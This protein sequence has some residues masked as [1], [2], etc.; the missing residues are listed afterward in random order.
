MGNG[1]IFAMVLTIATYD[2]IVFPPRRYHARLA[3]RCVPGTPD[4][5]IHYFLAEAD[6]VSPASIKNSNYNQ[7]TRL[8]RS[9]FQKQ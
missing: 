5:I 7:S 2:P 4:V 1:D 8:G 6:N 9:I 3:S